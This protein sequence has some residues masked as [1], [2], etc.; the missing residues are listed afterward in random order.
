[1]SSNTN[2]LEDAEG[3]YPDWIE[4]YND[5]DQSVNLLNFGLSDD[6]EELGKWTFPSIEIAS[7]EYM[8]V[9]A[10]AKD[11]MIGSELHTNFK[12]KQ[13]GESLILSDQS[14][15]VLHLINPIEMSTDLS[16]SCIPD[17]N[18][19]EMFLSFPSPDAQNVVLIQVSHPSG[20]YSND[21]SLSINCS[22]DDFQIYYTLN[23]GVPNPLSMH[24]SEP[25]DLDLYNDLEDDISFIPT[26]PLDGPGALNSIIWKEPIKVNNSYIL[27]YAAFENGV[28]VSPIDSK[29]YFV[30]NNKEIQYDFPVLSLITDSLNLFQHDTGIYIPGR[31]FEEL[32]W[33]SWYYHGNFLERGRDWEREVYVSFFEENG[34]LIFETD[35]G[36]RMRGFGSARF[37]QKS[38]GLY[39]RNE[40]GLSKVEYPIFEDSDVDTFK[41]LV[42]RNSGNDCLQTHFHDAILTDLLKP[43][44]LELQNYRASIVFFNG[45]YWG[46][47]GIREKYDDHYFKY[48]FGIEEDNINILN[49]VLQ[50]E[51]GNVADYP[52][53]I[54]FVDHN[55][56][57]LPE[58][59]QFVDQRVDIP[60]MIDFLIAEIYYA[61][62]DWPCNNY[63]KWKTNDEN[64][65]WRY[66]IYD[67][68]YSF[69]ISS[70]CSWDTPSFYHALVD[71][72]GWPNCGSSNQLFRGMMENDRFVNEFVN[73]FAYHLT[74]TFKS[75]TVI[76][77]IDEYTNM[78]EPEMQEHID[79]WG[80]PEN[81]SK[82][83]EYIDDMKEFAQ[84]R[85]CYMRQHIMEYFDL[86]SFGFSCDSL[87][88]TP[89]LYANDH[90][91]IYPN[92][93][94]GDQVNVDY[95]LLNGANFQIDIFSS[96]GRLIKTAVIHERKT[97]IE[98]SSLANG[99]Y[100]L[101]IYN[102]TQQ[103][104]YKL[105]IS[106]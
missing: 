84:E 28:Q 47:H 104:N 14:G 102:E 43:L 1:M 96:Q 41:R 66:L 92:P 24:Y 90:F 53:I 33:E 32:G 69:G 5:S 15:N 46:I 97:L 48:H 6:I 17:G 103:F 3:D 83:Y 22:N 85:P 63:K 31:K 68:D 75:S 25:I 93:V 99:F 8:V 101:K 12:I 37:S 49:W 82:W 81:I 50:I 13:S 98:V 2:T 106:H 58:S 11:V 42:F 80:Y 19:D 57:S 95:T 62:Y 88:Y 21:L 67:L 71:G 77:K 60:N 86:E 9:F 10:S 4:I 16:Y 78:L 55:D 70:T 105:L 91:K 64:S 45:E 39:F 61:N 76:D 100:I 29:T 18:I 79:R 74:N 26:T 30:S 38:F 40:Y 87:D 35:A 65:K 94:N 59:Y 51:E 72:S 44:D 54:Y 7:H 20:Y 89:D 73:R 56:M 27:R 52:E 34:D 23:G 36:M